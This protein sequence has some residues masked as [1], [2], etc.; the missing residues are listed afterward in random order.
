MQP[1]GQPQNNQLN[2][3]VANS[4]QVA[5]AN[6]VR[7]QIEDIYEHASSQAPETTHHN[8]PHRSISIEEWSQ[9]HS[10]WQ[11]YYQKYYEGYY[12][13]YLSAKQNPQT[14]DKTSPDINNPVEQAPIQEQAKK[15]RSEIRDK[16]KEKLKKTKKSRHFIP[17]ILA[18]VV[19]S[20]IGLAQYNRLIVASVAAYVSPGAIDPQNIIVD[21]NN[22]SVISKEPRLIIPKINIDVPVVYG[23]GNDYD[24]QMAAMEKG[25]AHFSIPGANSHPGEIGNTVI[26]GHSSNDIFGGGDYKFIFAQLEKLKPG[27]SIYANYNG[28]RYG[29]VITRT[30]VVKPNQ[31]DKLIIDSDKPMLTLVTCTPLGTATNRLL[32]FADQVTPDPAG[33]KKPAVNASSDAKEMPSNAPTFFEWLAGLFR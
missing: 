29:Y 26:A 13:Y 21:P 14:G 12:N 8:K 15:L 10:A 5:A 11:D 23:V 7:H 31:V 9:Y 6:I 25:A 4:Q 32:V 19:M 1:N 30:E 20:I 2:Q 17:L 18:L 28:V 22:P 27:D 16:V 24:S 33:A 3:P